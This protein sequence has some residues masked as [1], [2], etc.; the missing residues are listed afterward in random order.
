MKLSV[1]KT[2]SAIR[3]HSECIILYQHKY[4]NRESKDVEVSKGHMPL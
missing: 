1:Q 2:L 4:K 3:E